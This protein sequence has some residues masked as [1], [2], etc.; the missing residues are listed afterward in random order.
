MSDLP[1]HLPLQELFYRVIRLLFCMCST[2]V[3]KK[4]CANQD[5]ESI[6]ARTIAL[7]K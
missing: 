3:K 7:N 2:I 6:Y 4:A 1:L 5:K